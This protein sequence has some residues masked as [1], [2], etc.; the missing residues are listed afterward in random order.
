MLLQSDLDAVQ[1]WSEE[2]SLKLN[3]SKSIHMRFTFKK[4]VEFSSYKING[5][6]IPLLVSH[7]HLGIFIDNK[8]SWKNKFVI[9]E[10][11]PI[12]FL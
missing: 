9:K 3:E 1:K 10:S 5:Q 11:G 4:S 2:K 6:F 7:K 8:L 12:F